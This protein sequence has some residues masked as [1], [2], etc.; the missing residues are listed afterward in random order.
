MKKTTLIIVLLGISL[1]MVFSADIKATTADGRSVILHDNGRWEYAKTG[2]GN[3]IGKWALPDNYFDIII[4]A[5][6]SESGIS[7]YDPNY[8]FYRAY[9]QAIMAEEI[10]TMNFSSLFMLTFN[11]DGSV[12]AV[13]NGEENTGSY[14][15]D[16][17]SRLLTIIDYDTNQ[18]LPFGIF[19][20]NYSKLSVLGQ[21]WIYLVKQ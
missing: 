8:A 3:F 15:V 6:L 20:E 1:F 19:D 5:A 7:T 2:N 9:F 21:D 14:K 4:D 12:N 13:I 10:G 17:T 18:S 11:S 16:P